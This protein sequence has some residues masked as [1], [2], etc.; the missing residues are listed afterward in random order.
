M[1]KS[2]LLLF[3]ILNLIAAFPIKAETWVLPPSDIDVF[4]QIRTTHASSAE[5]LLDIARQYDIGQI[6]ILLA[7]P[8]VDR[9]LP[10]DG[11]EVILPSRYIIPHGD[12]KGLLLN[13]PEMRIY[14][15]PEPKK[16][17]KPMIITHPV[18]IGRMD[19]ITPLGT[20]KIVDKKKDPTWI[21]PKSL[22]MDRIANGEQPYPSIVPPGPTNPLGR[23][24]MRLGISSGSYL[25]HGTIKPFG[26]GM[27]VSAGCV[28]MYP[29]DI[30]ALFD[31][32]PVGTAVQI[33]NQPI[34][35]GW[36][37]DSLFIE[38]HPPLEEDEEK[39]TNY[40]HMVVTAINDFLALK[41]SKRTIPADF[42]ID[43]EALKQ[44]IMEKSGMPVLISRTTAQA[45]LHTQNNH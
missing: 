14:Y 32:V 45:Q 7:N 19:W 5:T 43:Q 33:V 29:E 38:L 21:P 25:I 17:E 39:Y 18:G 30:E 11:A 23:H 36:L 20:T 9:W 27:R 34:K 10:Q 13:L 44:A 4:G 37:L 35:L 3:A 1:R 40:K 16:G 26:V 2:Y 42:E 6:E 8:N 31:K 41:S 28:R 15:F 22:Q 12:R 24:A